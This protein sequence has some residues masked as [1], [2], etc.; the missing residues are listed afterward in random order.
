[1]ISSDAEA[2]PWMTV[3]SSLGEISPTNMFLQLYHIPSTKYSPAE[4]AYVAPYGR[5]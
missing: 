2:H 1:M 4:L 3:S 5:I